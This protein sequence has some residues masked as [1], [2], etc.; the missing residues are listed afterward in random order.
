MCRAARLIRCSRG[1]GIGPEQQ[2]EYFQR[3]AFPSRVMQRQ[4]SVLRS[5]L[6]DRLC[7]SRSDW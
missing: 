2:L 7:L 3:R 4:L 6:L 1:L 5:V